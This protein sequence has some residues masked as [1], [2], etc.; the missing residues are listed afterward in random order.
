M[1][2]GS[3]LWCICS[4]ITNVRQSVVGTVVIAVVMTWRY[5]IGISVI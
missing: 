4:A 3:V 1:H 5:L 2:I